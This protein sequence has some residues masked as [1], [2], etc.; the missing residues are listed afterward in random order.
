MLLI[1]V[2]E[3]CFY[4]YHSCKWKMTSLIRCCKLESRDYSLQIISSW[5][6]IGQHNQQSLLSVEAEEEGECH[7]LFL[8]TEKLELSPCCAAFL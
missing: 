6:A 7:H 8:I 2:H 1:S 5:K 4:Y 3:I